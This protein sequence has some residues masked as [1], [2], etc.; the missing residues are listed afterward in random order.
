MKDLSGDSSRESNQYWYTSYQ[1]DSFKILYK[2][3]LHIT[4][5]VLK[6]IKCR[7][8]VTIYNKVKLDHFRLY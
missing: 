7:H 5:L 4:A 3:Q 2:H 6:T 8:C 1:V